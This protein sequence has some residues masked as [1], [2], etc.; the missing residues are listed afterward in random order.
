[1][2]DKKRLPVVVVR[3]ECEGICNRLL[4][5]PTE[6]LTSHA[7]DCQRWRVAAHNAHDVFSPVEEAKNRLASSGGSISADLT[8]VEVPISNVLYDRG[9]RVANAGRLLR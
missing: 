9:R 3:S 1:V 2:S 8:S 5:T 7:A 6:S 4:S